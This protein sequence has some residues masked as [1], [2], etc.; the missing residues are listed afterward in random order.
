MPGEYYEWEEKIK[1]SFD[2]RIGANS[3]SLATARTIGHLVGS[4]LL[5]LNIGVLAEHL[6]AVAPGD[7]WLT[8]QTAALGSDQ[9]KIGPI[10]QR[11]LDNP[12][13]PAA[14]RA[15]FAAVVDSFNAAPLVGHGSA[16]ENAS[17]RPSMSA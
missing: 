17:S 12:L 1:A 5:S 16:A 7:S 3:P 4:A 8:A 11:A 10:L 15:P 2:S 13:L 9:S 14:A 6:R